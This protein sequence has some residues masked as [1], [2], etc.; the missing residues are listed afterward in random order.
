MTEKEALFTYRLKQ[1]EETISD[2]EK[3]LQE[4]LSPRSI[5]NRSFYSMFYAVL[6]LFLKTDINLKTSKHSGVISIFD[7]EFVHTG[8]IDKY[9][10]KILHKAFDARQ[11][12]D[13]K[14]FVELSAKDAAES[15]KLAREF[16]ECIKNIIHM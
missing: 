7:K 13:Y 9:Y 12:S 14:E 5:I 15:V 8:K 6:A 4:N 3:M 10:S 11:E 16:I 2:A 1:A